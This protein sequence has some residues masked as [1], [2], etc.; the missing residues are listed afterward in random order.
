LLSIN[1]SK[2]NENCLDTE[3]SLSI[4][5]NSTSSTN[6]S[7]EEYSEST[8]SLEDCSVTYFAGYIAFKCIKK[9]NCKYCECQLVTEKLLDEKTQLL[10]LN[11]N[12][13]SLDTGL[14]A[15]EKH[16]NNIMDRILIIFEKKFDNLQ[17]RKNI[18]EN[19]T[20]RIQNCDIINS[21]INI[22]INCVNHKLY[23]IRLLLICKIFLKNSTI[24]N[25]I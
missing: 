12:Y 1:Q 24:C 20:Q 10:I 2:I 18:R 16:F 4:S 5:V 8:V 13:S 14:K 19:L 6:S 11:K 15:P 21:W 23:I 9:C 17:H 7:N 22:N 3:E 25:N